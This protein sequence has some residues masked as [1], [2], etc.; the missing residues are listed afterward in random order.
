MLRGLSIDLYP[1]VYSIKDDDVY[2]FALKERERER[3]RDVIKGERDKRHDKK[4]E[5]KKCDLR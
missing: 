4:M 2:R 1:Y 5:Q 3:K